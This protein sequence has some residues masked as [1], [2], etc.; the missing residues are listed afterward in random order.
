MGVPAPSRGVFIFS[1]AV[2]SLPLSRATLWILLKGGLRMPKTTKRAFP[3]K[4]SGATLGFEEKLWAAA[5]K[6]RLLSAL[7]D[8]LLPRLMSGEVRVKDFKVI[9]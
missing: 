2:F 9:L 1:A 3:Y 7:R 8:A 6:L 5:N 4:T